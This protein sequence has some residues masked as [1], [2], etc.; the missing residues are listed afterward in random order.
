MISSFVSIPRIAVAHAGAPE[1]SGDFARVTIGRGGRTV[2]FL[3]DVAGHGPLAALLARDLERQVARLAGTMSSAALLEML[4]TQIEATWPADRFVAA[5]C[6][7]FDSWSGRGEVAVAGQL[8]PIVKRASGTGPIAV[9]SGPCLGATR[10]GGYVASDLFLAPGDAVVATTD[11]I[12]D[13]LASRSDLL[14]LA[15]AARIVDGA[16]PTPNGIC[17]A[18]LDGAIEAGLRDDATILVAV[19]RPFD[20]EQREPL[21]IDLPHAAEEPAAIA[22]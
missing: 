20:L 16:Q 8:P 5:V 22:A 11:G 1:S 21:A 4:N 14:G 19:H 18:L 2:C 13:P 17:A 15:A 10:A 6:F 3:G 12:T 7:S 9:S